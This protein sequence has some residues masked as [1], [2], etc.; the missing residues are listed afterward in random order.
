MQVTR[1]STRTHTP[2]LHTCM[3]TPHTT[4]MDAHTHAHAHTYTHTHTPHG[5]G[6]GV[7]V[8]ELLHCHGGAIRSLAHTSHGGPLPPRVGG[9]LA[10]LVTDSRGGSGLARTTGATLLLGVGRLLFHLLSRSG[11]GLA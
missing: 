4:H 1:P 11:S 6:S 5:I 8:D 10:G 7:V 2:M 3:H 9:L